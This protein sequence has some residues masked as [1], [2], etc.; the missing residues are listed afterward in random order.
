MRL[1]GEQQQ[2]QVLSATCTAL[3]TYPFMLNDCDENV[4][5][6]TGEEE[7]LYGWVAVNYLMDG[8]DKHEHTPDSKHASGS[9]Y[10]FLDMGGASTQI[11]FEPSESE[12]VK[13]ADNLVE[14]RLRLLSGKEVKHPV[15]VTTWLGFGTNRARD[16]YIDQEITTFDTESAVARVEGEV[17]PAGT[18]LVVEDPCLP[19]SLLLSDPRHTGYTLKGTGDFASCVRKTG[20]L[21]NKEVE[22]L[23]EPCLFNGVHVPKIDFSVN[24]FIGISEYWYALQD[25]WSMGGVYDFV[26]FEKNAFEYCEREW[27]DI[28]SDHKTGDKWKSTVELSRL[29]SQC[30]KAAWVINVLHEGIG[31]PRLID[32]GG[33][34]D[35]KDQTAKGIKMAK[36]K[37]LLTPPPTFQSVNQVGDVAVS[38]TLG[39]MVLE[40]SKDVGNSPSFNPLSRPE[41][42]GHIPSWSGD[43][44]TTFAS[45]KDV[46][47][48]PLVAFAILAFLAFIFCVS[49]RAS[50][51]AKS[52]LSSR[53]GGRSATTSEFAL[54]SQED[55][56]DS[57]GGDSSSSGSRSPSSRSNR[58]SKVSPLVSKLL[59]PVRWGAFVLSS[60]LR[61]WSRRVPASPL[62][63][64]QGSTFSSPAPI[65]P[66]LQHANSTPFMRAASA[67]YGPPT[68]QVYYNDAP[69]PREKRSAALMRSQSSNVLPFRSRTPPPPSSLSSLSKLSTM[70]LV[71]STGTPSPLSR[72]TTPSSNRGMVST[73][74]N[75][76]E[77]TGV[78]TPPSLSADMGGAKLR[79]SRSS[80]QVNLVG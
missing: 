66:R 42:S 18:V 58:S 35:G 25:I 30:F 61:S 78:I 6:I 51:R 70:G 76:E 39:K 77:P 2:G 14:V 19:K 34:G 47:P 36:E 26:T 80:G 75:T 38:W 45:M 13:H 63:P 49:R 29:E 11:A 53:R 62:L 3:R 9:T 65:R 8:F 54:V 48:F 32:S 7:G 52:F 33:E 59:K 27:D 71:S 74:A 24:H 44:R 31:I 73:L 17:I 43:L 15:F 68:G 40:V 64:T 28:M 50:R 16:R 79:Q 41:W 5:I 21:L 57:S 1:L 22:C 56:G 10:G 69:P 46:D 55:A 37:G 20:P 67:P 72:P 12:Q 60:S 4:R 23:D